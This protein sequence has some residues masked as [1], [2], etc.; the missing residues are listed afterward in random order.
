MVLM[1]PLVLECE[2]FQERA[3][4]R[5]V[6]SDIRGKDV[7]PECLESVKKDRRKNTKREMVEEW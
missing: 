4:L 5:P 7:S 3:R 6:V 1:F 2:A